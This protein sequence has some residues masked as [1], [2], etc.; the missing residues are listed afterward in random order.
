M[1][2]ALCIS[3]TA[4]LGFETELRSLQFLV[5]YGEGAHG[6]GAVS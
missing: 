6:G 4:K 5:R 2:A 3:E 1:Y